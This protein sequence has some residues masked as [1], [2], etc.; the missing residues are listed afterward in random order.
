MTGKVYF[1]SDFHLGMDARLSSIEREKKV[2]RWLD[3]V[4]Q[5]AEEIYI[6]GDLFDYWFEYK[7]TVP[8]GFVRILGKLA[9][10]RDMGIP[11][12]FF[13][14]NHDMWLFR[15]FEEELDIP[16]YRA[17]ITRCIKGKNF[18]IGHGDGLGPGDRGYKMLKAVFA[19]AFC[20]W[21]FKWIHPDVG[22]PL[23]RFFSQTSRKYT[24]DEAPFTNPEKEW[25]VHFSN[26]HRKTNEIDFYIFGHRHLPIDYR[27]TSGNA[28]YI[29]LGEWM[30]ACSYGVWDGNTFEIKFFESDITQIY[31]I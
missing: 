13:T 17:P 21:A 4:S 28:R 29:N 3:M 15:Y 24:G 30:H 20:Q 8:K 25:L 10:I 9:A 12:Y 18:F 14:G 19:N 16:T 23:M 26:Q 5:D 27:I 7:H 1:A 2:V 31:G 6:V 11:V 22:L